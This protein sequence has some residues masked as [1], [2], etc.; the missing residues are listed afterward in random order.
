[1]RYS[2]EGLSVFLM[3]LMAVKS[4]VAKGLSEKL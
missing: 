3:H 4:P 2:Y 1:M